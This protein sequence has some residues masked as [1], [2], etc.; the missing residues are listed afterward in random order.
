MK[1]L[2]MCEG[3]NELAII[4]LL[5]KHDAL[6]FSEDDLI[7]LT[8]YHARQIAKSTQVQLQLKM[9][10]GND[11]IVMRVGDKQNDSLT[12]PPDYRGKILRQE[13]Y[14]T[15][16]EL[17]ILLII[18]EGL[19]SEFEKTKSTV[20]PKSFSKAHIQ[21]GKRK[22]DGSTAFYEEYFGSKFERLIFSI[23][24][25]KRVRG[26]THAKDELCLADLLKQHSKT[27]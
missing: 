5:L 25:Y 8:P 3:P 4:R 13:K 27:E 9:Y 26:K 6:F 19:L 20:S 1:R 21:S 18:S 15:K 12:I 24:E 14:C 10:S 16:P 17:E 23:T 11:V 7:G 22:Y 2:I